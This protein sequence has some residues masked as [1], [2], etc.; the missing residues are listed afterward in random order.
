MK[1][2][3]REIKSMAKENMFTI[4]PMKLMTDSGWKGKNVDLEKQYTLMEINSKEIL[5]R[6]KGMAMVS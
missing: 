1:E 5:Q 6:A 3:G 4:V 2:S